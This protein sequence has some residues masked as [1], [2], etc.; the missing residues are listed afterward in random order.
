MAILD[1]L[2][3]IQGIKSTLVPK[4]ID[5]FTKQRYYNTSVKSDEVIDLK[6]AANFDP[7][8]RLEDFIPIFDEKE[9]TQVDLEDELGDFKFRRAE[10]SGKELDLLEKTKEFARRVEMT[11]DDAILWIDYVNF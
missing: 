11:P 6:R 2:N 9:D 7:D 5:E 4:S 8:I 1:D 3:K 10:M